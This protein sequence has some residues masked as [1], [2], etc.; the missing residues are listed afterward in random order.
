MQSV[1]FHLGDGVPLFSFLS[2][3][4]NVQKSPEREK[5]A[6]DRDPDLDPDAALDRDPAL[7]P[8][9]GPD[10]NPGTDQSRS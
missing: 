1:L 6:D 5:C 9:K 7:D 3:S 10:L 8:D 2:I 4:Y